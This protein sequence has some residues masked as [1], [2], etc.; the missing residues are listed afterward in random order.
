M[1]TSMETRALD[2]ASDIWIELRIMHVNGPSTNARV[3]TK[4]I[5]DQITAAFT[6]IRVEAIEEVTKELSA[7][8]NLYSD[9]DKIPGGCLYTG[10]QL[11]QL[12]DRIRALAK[13]SAK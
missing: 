9:V 7:L 13:G 6:Q 3:Y 5:Q 11:V 4:T 10:T 8:M 2:I 12:R 1:T